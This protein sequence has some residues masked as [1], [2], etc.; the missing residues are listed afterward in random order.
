MRNRSILLALL[1][2]SF[3]GVAQQKPGA[4]KQPPKPSA[5]TSNAARAILE[6]YTRR[7]RG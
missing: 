7:S 6:K 2:L 1:A 3:I 4:K 5:S